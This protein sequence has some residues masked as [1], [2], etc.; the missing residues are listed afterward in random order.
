[1]LDTLE[2]LP[3]DRPIEL[4][5]TGLRYQE[6]A[7]RVL[8]TWGNRFARLVSSDVEPVGSSQH[9]G[10]LAQRPNSEV[11]SDQPRYDPRS[12]PM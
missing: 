10:R 1:M 5:L 12:R 11:V 3:A 4:D 6:H 2:A 7:S 9:R 8:R